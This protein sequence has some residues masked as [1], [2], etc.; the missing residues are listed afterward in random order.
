MEEVARELRRLP[1]GLY[2]TE[3]LLVLLRRRLPALTYHQLR[4]RLEALAEKG[5]VERVKVRI[6]YV[7]DGRRLAVAKTLWRLR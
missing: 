1:R 7:Y 3:D 2:S 4:R 5:L 6:I